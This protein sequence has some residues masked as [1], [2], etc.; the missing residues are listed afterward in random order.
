MNTSRLA[1]Y[2]ASIITATAS[3]R[4]IHDILAAISDDIEA[5]QFQLI[6]LDRT[7]LEQPSEGFC[8]RTSEN[9]LSASFYALETG[10]L[11]L[12][13]SR[14]TTNSQFDPRVKRFLNN[15]YPHLAIYFQLTLPDL[16]FNNEQ[17]L[18]RTRYAD[19]ARPLWVINRSSQLLYSNEL[20]SSCAAYLISENGVLT[21]NKSNTN[22]IPDVL[23]A[24]DSPRA[25]SIKPFQ[26]VDKTTNKNVTERFWIGRTSQA[27]RFMVLGP[28]PLPSIEN[29]IDNHC[30]SQRK[31]EICACIM[32]GH[33]I[34]STAEVLA[35]SSN[36]VRNVLASCF[37]QFDVRNQ[38]ELILRLLIK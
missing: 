24:L 10:Q 13:F 37:D 35:I 30:L 5:D 7:D 19:I 18:W 28:K 12:S 20:T 38:S 3:T 21:T 34:K 1:H 25:R 32:Q 29:L 11:L 31:A 8:I 9:T 17:S 22:P 2:V 15:L 27:N 23:K 14:H 26:L 16:A 4:S 36:T 33:S 6:A